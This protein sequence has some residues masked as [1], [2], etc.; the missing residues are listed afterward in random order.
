MRTARADI[1]VRETGGR[2]RAG[3]SLPATASTPSPGRGSPRV[4]GSRTASPPNAA[5][6]LSNRHPDC[7]HRDGSGAPQ[8]AHRPPLLG[9]V[10]GTTSPIA[11][12]HLFGGRSRRD[13]VVVHVVDE[14]ITAKPVKL[15]VELVQSGMRRVP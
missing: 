8:D 12:M 5:R 13:G 2:A 7:V 3:G 9:V 1:D 6:T 10:R 11:V 14:P 4:G 15:A